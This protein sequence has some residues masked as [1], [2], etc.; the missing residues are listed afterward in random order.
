MWVF[1]NHLWSPGA[2]PRQHRAQSMGIPRTGPQSTLRQIH[3]HK[4]HH[5]LRLVFR[6][7][8]AWLCVT[9]LLGVGG[10]T[11]YREN[12]QPPPHTHTHRAEVEPGHI[13]QLYYPLNPPSTYLQNESYTLR[14]LKKQREENWEAEGVGVLWALSR[15]TNCSRQAPELNFRHVRYSENSVIWGKWVQPNHTGANHWVL[16]PLR[17]FFLG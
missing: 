2:Y 13:R 7:K 12:M 9:V 3:L 15:G 14:N 11:L 4:H 6:H 8:L 16:C 5:L 10:P 17:D 1:R